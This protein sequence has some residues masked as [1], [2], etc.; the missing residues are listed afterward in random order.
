[1]GMVRP[2]ASGQRSSRRWFMTTY[3]VFFFFFFAGMFSKLWTDS[4]KSAPLLSSANH[5][6]VGQNSQDT[7]KNTRTFNEKQE[8]SSINLNPGKREAVSV[9]GNIA[10][11]LEVA[12]PKLTDPNAGQPVESFVS[13]RLHITT[14]SSYPYEDVSL[15]TNPRNPKVQ[16]NSDGVAISDQFPGVE[17]WNEEL[18]ADVAFFVQVSEANMPLVTRLIERLWHERNIILVHIDKKAPDAAVE[19]FMEQY[20]DKSTQKYSNLH[21]LPR[22]S[23]TYSGVS[24]LLN[25][26]S[27]MEYLLNLPQRWDYFINLSGSDYPCITARNLRI[28][29]GQPRI[30]RQRVSFL[31]LGFTSEFEE[32]VKRFRLGQ[33]HFDPSL[34]LLPGHSTDAELIH[35]YK[36]NPLAD[37]L[38][39]K[40][41]QN[42]AWIMAH[43]SLAVSSVRSAFARRLLVLL[44]VSKDPEEHFFGMLA[45]ND[46]QFNRTLARYAGRGVYWTLNGKK[47][48]QHPYQIDA[49]RNETGDFAFWKPVQNQPLLFA[50][51]FSIP[52]SPL[53]DLI[54]KYKS[55][56]HPESDQERVR[57][58]LKKV[59]QRFMCHASIDKYWSSPKFL[60]CNST[61]QFFR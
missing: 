28:L 18:Q 41:K 14:D 16:Y 27:A 32:K 29:L 36:V 1:M 53:M 60:P 49:H 39:I 15:L 42:E 3:T 10:S 58:S 45:W 6:Q 26:L 37:Q 43:R 9:H 17:T 12:E 61:G 24:M 34:G 31:Q 55:G 48:G 56:V 47:S 7:I 54:D 44:A 5:N 23:V 52:D 40:F 35:T 11:H 57:E 20:K 30:N 51:K 4:L 50:R 59:R 22:Q 2:M 25:T 8:Q 19:S 33:I 46:P 38:D 13:T 21:F